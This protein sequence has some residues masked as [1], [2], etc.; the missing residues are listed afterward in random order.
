MRL[1]IMLLMRI[2]GTI[3]VMA[4]TNATVSILMIANFFLARINNTQPVACLTLRSPCLHYLFLRGGERSIQLVTKL[5]AI[6][7]NFST[8]ES[9]RLGDRRT[10]SDYTTI[11]TDCHTMSKFNSQ[12]S[13][14]FPLQ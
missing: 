4:T 8:A 1:W 3:L 2:V 7:T 14:R 10:V 6:E 13:E 12:A 5:L 9:V 11:P